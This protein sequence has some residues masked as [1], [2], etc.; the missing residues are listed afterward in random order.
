MSNSIWKAGDGTPASRIVRWAL[1]A[2]MVVVGIVLVAGDF[3]TAA[4]GIGTTLIAGSAVVVFA[5]W[6]GRLG[7]DSDRVREAAAREQFKR[8]GRWP[9]ED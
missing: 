6:F 4:L 7:D 8:T 3:G 2:L 9:D 1:P 5:G